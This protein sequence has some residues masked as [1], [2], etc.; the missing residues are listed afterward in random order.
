MPKRVKEEGKRIKI[1]ILDTGIDLKN[2]WIQQKA[3]RIRC[4]PNDELCEDTDGHGTQ[5]AYLLLRLAP[6]A[7]I[8]VAKIAKSQMLQDVEVEEI[9]KVS[10]SHRFWGGND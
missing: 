9:A 1:A 2:S 6:H 10:P 8:Q 7:Q 3:G 5:V 4:W